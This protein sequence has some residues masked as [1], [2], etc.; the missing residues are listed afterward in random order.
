MDLDDEQRWRIV[1]R[2]YFMQNNAHVNC[3][4]FNSN[5]SLLVVGFSNGIFSLYELPDFNM[6]HTLRYSQCRCTKVSQAYNLQY[7]AARY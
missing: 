5:A 6:I 4:A 1:D 7:I 3:A 2:H